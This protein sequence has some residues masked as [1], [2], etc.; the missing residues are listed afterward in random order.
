LADAEAKA[1][2]V[3]ASAAAD[4]AKALAD[5][6]AYATR[7]TADADAEAINA[8]AGALSGDNQPLIAANK[9]VDMLPALVQA[10]AH[11][12]EGAHLTVLNGSNGVNDIATGIAAQGLSI[13]HAL[14]SALRASANG[15]IPTPEGPEAEEALA[16]TQSTASPSAGGSA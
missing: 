9:L 16:G 3:S 12:I 5:G 1:Q 7:A 8:R 11:G 10:S 13:Y 4:A 6:D 15:A 14:Q 2:R